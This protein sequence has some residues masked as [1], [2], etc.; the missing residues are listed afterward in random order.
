LSSEDSP[1]P[2]F[3]EL[4]CE[5]V[6]DGLYKCEELN[7]FLKKDGVSFRLN[8]DNSNERIEIEVLDIEDIVD[9]EE[10]HS[11][12]ETSTNIGHLV[13]RMEAAL[14]KNDYSLVVHSSAS[15]F[16]TLAKI[17]VK[18]ASVQDKTLGSFFDSYRK[19]SSLPDAFLDYIKN[20]YTLRNVT[21][22]AGHGSTQNPNLTQKEAIVIFE[23]T[24]ALVKIEHRLQRENYSS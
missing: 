15:I 11:L 13:R 16:E 18:G 4:L 14:Q 3:A 1:P 9:I 5:F 6:N 23:I 24:K 21:P 19:D 2:Q 8:N 12:M 10:S 22:L 20:I 7:E 17:V